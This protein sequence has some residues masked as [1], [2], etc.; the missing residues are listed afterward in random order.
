MIA[1][2]ILL[3]GVAATIDRGAAGEGDEREDACKNSKECASGPNRAEEEEEVVEHRDL[4]MN[5]GWPVYFGRV[6]RMS[7]GGSD[8]FSQSSKR[9]NAMSSSAWNI[10]SSSSGLGGSKY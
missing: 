1:K 8:D 3:P 5:T 4:R 2:T 6:A 7:M 9:E 10:W